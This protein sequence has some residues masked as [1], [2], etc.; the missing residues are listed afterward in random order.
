MRL[1]D[2]PDT[3]I[4]LETK[5]FDLLADVKASAA[6]RWVDAV[7]ADGI[8]GRWR[9]ELARNVSSVGEKLSSVPVA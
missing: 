5:G 4:I 6:A 8:H 1:Q 9:Y 2:L 7:N 3:T